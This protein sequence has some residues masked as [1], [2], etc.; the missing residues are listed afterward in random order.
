MEFLRLIPEMTKD[1]LTIAMWIESRLGPRQAIP[2]A[3]LS[4]RTG[5]DER[6]V[7]QIVKHLIERHYLPI[8]S[9]VNPGG[10]YTI[11]DNNERLRVRRALIRRA[12][13]ILER[14][15]AYD[16]GNWINGLIGQLEMQLEGAAAG[17]AERSAS[18][19]D[20]Q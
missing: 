12:V 7:R 4:L 11:S 17:Q 9:S 16:R 6:R 2:V 15:R 8:G 3:E 14:A 10:Y 19:H 1:E 20:Q 5:L 13:S 18:R